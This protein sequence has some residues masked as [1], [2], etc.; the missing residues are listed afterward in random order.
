MSEQL[1]AMVMVW[2]YCHLQSWRQKLERL[3]I[4]VCKH[5]LIKTLNDSNPLYCVDF[6]GVLQHCL[7]FFITGVCVSQATLEPRVTRT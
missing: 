6:M 1:R 5:S 7:W 2:M 4:K 3:Q